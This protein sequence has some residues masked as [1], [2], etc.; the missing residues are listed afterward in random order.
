MAVDKQVVHLKNVNSFFGNL[1]NG[2][3]YEG[4]WGG[5]TD[6]N[7]FLGR[8]RDGIGGG[9]WNKHNPL[10]VA[11][12]PLGNRAVLCVSGPAC[13]PDREKRPSIF[14]STKAGLLPAVFVP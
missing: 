10:I 3:K 14:L 1:R 7:R 9:R 5:F 6:D 4:F 11:E 13:L 12:Q 8:R 2:G